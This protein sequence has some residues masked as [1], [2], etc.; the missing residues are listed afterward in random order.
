[1]KFTMTP[2]THRNYMK[3]SLGFVTGMMIYFCWFSTEPA[4]CGVHWRQFAYLDGI[5][6]SVVSF[7]FFL[8]MFAIFSRTLSSSWTSLVFAAFFTVSYF[9][10][11]SVSI[12]L[13]SFSLA[14]FTSP[15]KVIPSGFVFEKFTKRFNFFAL[16]ARFCYNWFR[17]GFSLIKKL[18]LEPLESQSLCGSSYYTSLFEGVK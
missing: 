8:V 1:M 12:L 11:F 17:H 6:D 15:T 13:M 14:L 2:I 7:D 9:T 10:F 5:F 18:C 4:F 16:P 3:S